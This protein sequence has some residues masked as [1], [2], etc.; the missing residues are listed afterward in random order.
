VG[1]GVDGSAAN[2][3]SNMLDEVRNALLLQRIHF[4]AGAMSPTQA[5]ELATLGSARVLGRD[6]IGQ[7]V[8]GKAA[9]VIAV[10]LERLSFAGGLHDPVAALVL[11]DAGR[12]DLTIV[13]GQVRVRDGQ[14][15]DLDLRELIKRQN[16]LASE[17]VRRTEKRY[18][19]SL[20]V[21]AWRRAY[22][23]DPM[24]I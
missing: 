22:P 8:P 19:L 9:D 7:L 11:C 5:L 17:L 12:V 14:L 16:R 15:V 18:N 23:Y 20:H 10:D 21:P 2:N 24:S 13:N 3:S 4:G 6:D 1:L